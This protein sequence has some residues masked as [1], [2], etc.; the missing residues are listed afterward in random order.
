[1]YLA[2][3]TKTSFLQRE[4]VGFWYLNILKL[5]QK[6]KLALVSNCKLFRNVYV[7]LFIC[8]YFCTAT[9]V[10]HIHFLWLFIQNEKKIKDLVCSYL[11]D[12]Q[13]TRMSCHIYF[14]ELRRTK[15]TFFF[16]LHSS[17]LN[18]KFQFCLAIFF[19]YIVQKIL[20]IEFF[21]AFFLSWLLMLHHHFVNQN[22]VEKSN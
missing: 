8:I 2:E 5:C 13:Y 19:L 16:V 11:L 18:H 7:L 15:T 21:H 22:A 4:S 20:R 17:H 1:M 3:Y 12:Q 10:F 14:S 9:H 6:F